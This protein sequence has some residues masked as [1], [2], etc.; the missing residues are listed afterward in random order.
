MSTMGRY[1]SIPSKRHL[2]AMLRTFGYLKNHMKLWIIY[3]TKFLEDQGEVDIE[4][5]WSELYPNAVEDIPPEITYPKGNPV[6]M[7]NFVDIDHTYDIETR[8]SVNVLIIFLNKTQSSGTTGGI[9]MW[10]PQ[11]TAQIW[12]P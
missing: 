11:H 6:R 4:L 2:G 1:N 9:I 8:W 12:C 7:N 5:N 10:K 3:D